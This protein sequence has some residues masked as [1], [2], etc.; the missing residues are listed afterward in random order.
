MFTITKEFRFAAAHR[1]V[2]ETICN[3]LHGHSYRVQFELKAE[4]LDGGMVVDYGDLVP[5]RER[6][7]STLD[8]RYLVSN[9]LIDADDPIY[10]ACLAHAPHWMVA[11]DI[12]SSTA[13]CLARWFYGE[14]S[15]T[16][17]ELTS[18]T[19]CEEAT[20]TAEYRF[21]RGLR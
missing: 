16:Y 9:E 5:V 21:E 6:I 11:I 7:D 1:I 10:L 12:P 13:E 20:T 4:V 17:P 15:G 8:H 19:V 2:G 18:V 14:W 3:R